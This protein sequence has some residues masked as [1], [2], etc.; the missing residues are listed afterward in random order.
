[1]FK[2]ML[3]RFFSV[4][5]VFCVLGAMAQNQPFADEYTVELTSPKGNLYGSLVVPTGDSVETVVLIVPG[6]GPTDRNGNQKMM[7]NNAYR[8]LAINLANKNIATLR[9]DKRGIGASRSAS[10]N[11]D[12]DLPVYIDDVK[13]WINYL[14]RDGRFKKVVLLGHSEGALV[15]LAA[16]HEGSKVNGLVSVAGM[17]RS[18]DQALRD[19]LADEPLYVRNI[20]GRII[21]SLKADLNVSFVPFYLS[22]MFRPEVQP[23]MRS[24]M[25]YD[26]Q[27]L[28]RGINT[29]IVVIQGDTDTQAKVE[30]ARLLHAANH[31]SRLII[32][33]GMNH[34]LKHCISLDR[35]DQ[36]P[37]YVNPTLPI[38]P[39]LV[40]VITDFTHQIN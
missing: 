7:R 29:P 1:M 12:F 14:R 32:I 35:V 17:G 13:S 19:Q 6:G 34:V 23:F 8:M 26:P 28:I 36:I 30:D 3:K 5:F 9:Y 24:I 18:F 39:D 11:G 21:D 37:T 15:S 4:Q 38:H 40:D 27:Q 20:S 33:V 2:R 22:S 31:N 16:I 10:Q 25:K